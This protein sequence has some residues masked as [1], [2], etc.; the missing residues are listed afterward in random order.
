MLILPYMA[1]YDPDAQNVFDGLYRFSRDQPSQHDP[2][3]MAWRQM[4]GCTSSSDANSASDGDLNI[5]FGLLLAHTQWGSKGTIDYRSEALRVLAAIRRKVIHPTSNL[6]QMGDWVQP[7]SP[8]EYE[9]VRT[10]DLMPMQLRAFYAV[11]GLQGW[12]NTL[13]ASLSLLG[14][15]QQDW[16]PHTGLVPD[17]AVGTTGRGRPAEAGFVGESRAGQYSFNACRVPWQTAIDYLLNGSSSAK[18]ITQKMLDWLQVAA[19]NSVYSIYGGYYLNGVPTVNWNYICFTGAFGVG[20]MLSPS[21]QVLLN[22]IWDD[23]AV[24][25]VADPSDYYG[26]TLRMVYLLALSGNLWR[27]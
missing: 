24:T 15:L 11:T 16:A 9:A 4:G 25:T 7:G 17:F 27:P 12:S 8:L 2:N 5:A 22:T 3:L 6:I 20:A 1:G 13:Q 21:R 10:S 26:S 23:V 18:T 19:G 14:R